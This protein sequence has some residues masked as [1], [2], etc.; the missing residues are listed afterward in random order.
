MVDEQHAVQ[1]IHLVLEADREQALDLFLVV[2]AVEV[3]PARA[4]AD[5]ADPPR[6]I[7]RGPTGSPRCRE[8]PGRSASRISGLMKTCGSFTGSPSSFLRLLQVDDQ[9]ALRDAD[10]DRG[11]ADA[12]R[13]VHRL[14]HVADEPRKSSSTRLDGLEISAG[15]GP[16]LQRSDRSAMALI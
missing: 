15:A 14:E 3:Q 2:L 16:E 11:K 9:Q 12:R 8:R 6:R 5:P 10:L 7:G 4:D 13:L 1:M